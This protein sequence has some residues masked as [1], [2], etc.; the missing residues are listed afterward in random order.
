[1]GD[2][3]DFIQPN[4]LYTLCGPTFSTGDA[5]IT[6]LR[7]P[8]RSRGLV[9]ERGVH[10]WSRGKLVSREVRIRSPRITLEEGVYVT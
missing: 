10:N 3:D 6:R 4:I 1:M 9:E 7:L 8:S 2:N 5:E